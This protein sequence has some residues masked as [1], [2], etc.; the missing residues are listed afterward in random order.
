MD[1]FRK[2][3]IKTFQAEKLGSDLIRVADD[4]D[5]LALGG[6]RSGVVA[7]R[8]DHGIGLDRKGLA[9]LVLERHASLSDL[10]QRGL[11]IDGNLIGL[12]EITQI[13]GVGK[14]NAGGRDEV[15]LHLNDDRL[16]AVQVEI[17]GDLT[18]GQASA[19]DDDTLANRLVAQQVVNGLDRRLCALD[20]DL[21][22]NGTRC[23]DDLVGIQLGYVL[24][25]GVYSYCRIVRRRC[26]RNFWMPRNRLRV[27]KQLVVN[28]HAV[29]ICV[30]DI[31]SV[32][33]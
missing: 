27:R 28:V 32:I 24:D 15:V 23:D 21:L 18:A 1:R 31:C 6:K 11:Q 13:A 7:N 3:L 22:G 30:R 19:N 16:L 20:G 26:N 8:Q 17:V 25:F 9:L 2:I 29:R 12:E 4:V 10:A 5:V 14:A 33:R